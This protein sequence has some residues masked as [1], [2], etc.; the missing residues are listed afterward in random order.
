MIAHC[1]LLAEIFP[2]RTCFKLKGHLHRISLPPADI[3]ISSEE[4][5]RIDINGDAPDP[6]ETNAIGPG[7]MASRRNMPSG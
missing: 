4:T 1:Y 6:A 5:Y 2:E 3:S 7:G